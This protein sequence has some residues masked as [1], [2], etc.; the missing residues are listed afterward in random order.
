MF[1]SKW[2]GQIS[3]GTL[4]ITIVALVLALFIEHLSLRAQDEPI[5]FI[6]QL[7]IDAD[8][9]QVSSEHQLTIVDSID[10]IAVYRLQGSD[11]DAY[12]QL[13]VDPRVVIVENDEG[14]VSFQA[15]Q[16][17][18]TSND[19]E[20]LQ[21]YLGFGNGDKGFID[22]SPKEKALV[23]RKNYSFADSWLTWWEADVHL[24]RAHRYSSGT[25][26]MGAVLDTGA[27][28]DHPAIVDHLVAGYDFVDDDRWPDDAPNGIDEDEDGAFDEGAGHGTYISGAL[29]KVAPSIQ[30]MPIRVLNSDGTGTLFDIVNGIIYAVDQGAD[31]INLSLSAHDHFPLL[32]TA[33]AYAA[34]HD[35]IVIAAAAGTADALYFP[36]AYADVIAVGATRRDG[37]VTEFSLPYANLVDVFAPGE[38]I[39]GPYYDGGYAWWSGSSM[40]APII[41][42]EAALLIE[43]G[44]CVPTC[45]TTL[46]TE[47]IQPVIQDFTAGRA[48]AYQAIIYAQNSASQQGT[49]LLLIDKSTLNPNID[50]IE[51]AAAQHNR[52]ANWLINQDLAT[53]TSNP[54]L[55]WNEF[56]PSDAALLPGGHLTDGGWF[57]LLPTA[58]WSLQDFFEGQVPE[59]QLA[60]VK[61]VIPLSNQNL[62]NLLGRT[63]V[64]IAYEDDIV[65][66]V[67]KNQ[68]DLRGKRYGRFA[69][70]VLGMEVP[71][72]ETENADAT[73]YELWVRVEPPLDFTSHLAISSVQTPPDDLKFAK[74]SHHQ[75]TLSVKVESSKADALL[76]ISVAI[77]GEH[78]LGGVPYLLEAPMIYDAKKD[79]YEFTMTTAKDLANWRIM[80]SSNLGG[81]ANYTE[82]KKSHK[83]ST[84]GPAN[85]RINTEPE[86]HLFLPMIMR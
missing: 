52:S 59:E 63:C 82:G 86:P 7:A 81:V 32:E 46:L 40:A 8:P 16:R 53:T 57:A 25:G 27:D 72:G 26:V 34:S 51:N 44:A 2:N 12:E 54:W 70:T 39:Y 48:D 76:T 35:V 33:V 36:A 41:A 71:D 37:Y 64:A 14:I 68:T 20:S 55:R 17:D 74:V 13:V 9:V 15:E 60:N 85:A 43:Q 28:L 75:E 58:S 4:G 80:I 29:A 11:P 19:F 69:F 47:R 23:V 10:A 21:H 24:D 18:F 67:T 22:G 84:L 73:L 31:I 45:V 56:F 66:D 83:G 78:V 42:G 6:V 65:V 77:D 3:L 50:A 38:L 79:N 62:A 30:I 1:T 5:T 61:D 49:C